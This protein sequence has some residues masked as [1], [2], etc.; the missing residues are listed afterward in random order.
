MSKSDLNC[1]NLPE[2]SPYYFSKKS[3]AGAAATMDGIP[4]N[5]EGPPAFE[6]AMLHRNRGLHVFPNDRF[7]DMDL[8]HVDEYEDSYFYNGDGRGVENGVDSTTYF[9]LCS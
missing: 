2:S 7:T 1:I 5:Q 4:S 6:D 9:W 8:P 3:S